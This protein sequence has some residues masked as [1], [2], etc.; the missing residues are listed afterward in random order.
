MKAE[1]FYA[2]DGVVDSTDPGW[3]QS[4]LNFLTGMFDQVGLCG[5]QALPGGRVTGRQSLHPE[6]YGRG[7]KL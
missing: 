1:F 4:A 6:D 5:V 2:D 3:L 7:E